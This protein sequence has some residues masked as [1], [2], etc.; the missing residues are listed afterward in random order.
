MSGID[1]GCEACRSG[2]CE[3]HGPSHTSAVLS[4]VKKYG[5]EGPPTPGEDTASPPKTEPSAR[6]RRAQ[7]VTKRISHRNPVK[8]GRGRR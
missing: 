7:E 6:A 1:F 8:G 3:V 2:S 5:P 4:Y